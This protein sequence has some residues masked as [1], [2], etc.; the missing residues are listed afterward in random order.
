VTAVATTFSRTTTALREAGRDAWRAWGA[1]AW[2]AVAAFALAALAPLVVPGSVRLDGLAQTGYL[3]VAAVGLGFVIGIGGMPSLAQGAFVGVGAV[4]AGHLVGWGAPA[5]LSALLGALIAGCGGL[6]VGAGVVRFRPVYVVAGTW[7]ATWVFVFAL[8]GFP[9]LSG[10]ARGLTVSPGEI[11]GFEPSATLHYE[12]ALGLVALSLL[13]HRTLAHS[14]FGLCLRAAGRRPAAAVALG[15][16]PARLRLA[17]FAGGAAV[18]GLAGGF[19]VQ[20]DGVVDTE[21]YGALLSFTLLVAVLVGGAATALGP[22]VG[23]LAVGSLSLVADA[24][25][26]VTGTESAR[27]SP[28]LAA[29]LLLS[30][31]AMGSEG[32]VPAVAARLRRRAP[33]P[34]SEVDEPQRPAP[35]SVTARGLEKRFGELVAVRDLDLELGS[36]RVAA[37]IGPN[38]SGKTTALR[39]LAGTLSPEAGSVAL[40]GREL[41]AA[42]ASELVQL[43]VVR[44]LQS[45][46]VFGDLTTLENALVGASLRRR[47]GGP[48]RTLFATP[49]ARA[50]ARDARARALAALAAV[51]LEDRADEL[52]E[53]LPGS[54]QRLVMLASA[55]ATEPRVLLL[56][57][58]S[59]GASSADLDRL[60][61]ILR[62][63]RDEGFAVLAVEHNLRLVRRI[64]DEVV[65]LNA[66]TPLARG[67]PDEVAG[68][69]AVRAAYLGR[70][71]L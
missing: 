56:D 65:V 59:A 12:L 57:E 24:I 58:P 11:A 29:L 43:G 44:T 66:G 62:R 2:L 31:L 30:V 61:L 53:T 26:R 18:A 5:V 39:I 64:A 4:A 36:E 28:M 41:R 32:I 63:L 23:V 37:L 71:H 7:I 33:A 47:H 45:T 40:D 46:A 34:R 38:G 9:S 17:A 3:A 25:A 70:Q 67:A 19:G 16:R 55:L 60:A 27:F 15:V 49:K 48:L 54:E 68:D 8:E 35:A 10:G 52:A 21:A 42:P 1:G 50:E 51:G 69:P 20:L 13:A 22:V 6:V 14:S